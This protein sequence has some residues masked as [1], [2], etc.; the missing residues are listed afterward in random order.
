MTT[1]YQMSL[2]CYLVQFPDGVTYIND[3]EEELFDLL[4]YKLALQVIKKYYKLYGAVPSK[5]NAQQFLEEI[6]SETPNVTEEITRDLREVVEDMYFPLP[7][8]DKTKIQ[9]TLILEVQQKNIE[10]TFMDYAAGKISTN[11]VFTKINKLSSL[12][13]S[14]GEEAHTDGGFLVEDREKHYNEQVQGHPTFLHDLNMMTAAKGFYAPQLIIFMSGPKHFKT[15]LLIKLG[16]EYARC[17]Y[18]VYYADGENGA[19]SIRN[20]AKMALLEC[21]YSELYDPEIQEELN[22]LLYRFKKYMGGDMFIDSYPANTKCMNDVKAR[23]AYLRDEYGWAPDVLIF[24]SIDHF[25]PNNSQDQKR[26]VRIRIQLVYHEAINLNRELGTFSFAPSQINRDA[27]KKKT[28]DMTD[29]SEDFGKAMNAHAIFAICAS[30]EEMD[31]GERR[32]VPI[33]Q[34]EGV[35]PG[36]NTMC[37][38]ELDE[39]RMIIKEVDKEKYFKDVKDD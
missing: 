24:D 26:D 4:E 13:R 8:G 11:Q 39:A 36:K 6:L 32:I 21:E 35:K 37:M 23:L 1:D 15:G 2:L 28:F 10:S 30:P 20:R 33:V 22:D 27:L 18:N 12:V 16:L 19:R 17:G 25:I 34:R 29:L 3:L 38:I 5:V 7:A 9:D 31:K 14:V